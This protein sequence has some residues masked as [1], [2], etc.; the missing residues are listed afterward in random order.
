MT[1][2]AWIWA[3][4]LGWIALVFIVGTIWRMVRKQQKRGG[5]AR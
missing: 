4:G 2:G 5:D 1:T 3:V